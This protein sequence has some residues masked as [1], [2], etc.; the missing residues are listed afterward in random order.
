[1]SQPSEPAG[2]DFASTAVAPVAAPR[3]R[4]VA[5]LVDVEPTLATLIAEW[6]D[7]IGVDARTEAPQ[8]PQDRDVDLVVVDVPYPRREGAQRVRALAAALPQAPILAL[9]STFFAGRLRERQRRPRPRRRGRAGD[10]SPPRRA[11]RGGS[12]SA[13][14]FAMKASA[15]LAPDAGARSWRH[16]AWLG[17]IVVGAIVGLAIYDTVRGYDAAVAATGR[18]LEGQAIVFAEQTARS[19]QAIDVVLR[20]LAEQDR[21]G[22]LRARSSAELHELLR[23][24]AVGLVQADG[25]SLHDADGNTLALSWRAPPP[26]ELANV[27]DRPAFQVVRESAADGAIVGE[28]LTSRDG[29]V[30]FFPIARRLTTPA[31]KF[32]GVVVARGRIAYFQNFYRDALRD[33]GTA[34][35]LLHREG[36][37]LARYPEARSALGK[38]FPVV[39]QMIAAAEKGE[40]PTR[41]ASPIDGID[42][43][44]AVAAVPDYPLVV[45]VTRDAPR[46]SDRGARRRCDRGSARWRLPDWRWSCSTSC[47][48]RCAVS[49]PRARRSRSRRSA[50]P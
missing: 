46:R 6:L 23:E 38:K 42:R 10:A 49:T 27:S 5:L 4:P 48:D 35:A 36:T 1:M 8:R 9:S 24:Q 25:L 45:T 47:C 14:R 22:T 12:R 32:A 41:A 19:I 33:P 13:A 43:F 44:G 39:P 17:A 29:N 18:E 31:G 15:W 50:S 37:L 2:T 28:A 3:A 40:G 21:D 20:H 7:D 16:V 30:E 11:R 26:S 34:V